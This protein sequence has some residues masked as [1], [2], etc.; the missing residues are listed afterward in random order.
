[1]EVPQTKRSDLILRSRGFRIVVAKQRYLEQ[2]HMH[3]GLEKWMMTIMVCA[4]NN[5]RL[6]MGWNHANEKRLGWYK[7]EQ[8]I[9]ITIH[10]LHKRRHLKATDVGFALLMDHFSSIPG[11]AAAATSMPGSLHHISSLYPLLAG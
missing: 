2:A 3:D 5:W 11:V 7:D 4:N 8:K 10:K 1:M 6:E 9:S